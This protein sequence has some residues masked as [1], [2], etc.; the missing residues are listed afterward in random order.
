MT[1]NVAVPVIVGLAAGIAFLAIFSMVA[2]AQYRSHLSASDLT[3][4][5]TYGI[6]ARVAYAHTNTA[7]SCPIS[8]CDTSGFVL[9]MVSKHDVMILGYEVCNIGSTCLYDG[10]MQTPLLGTSKGINDDSL[11]DTDGLPIY[12]GKKSGGNVGDT[13]S[14]KVRAMPAIEK[15]ENNIATWYGDPS[16]PPRWIDLGQSRI[17][18]LDII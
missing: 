16:E 3:H 17:L 10:E 6:D 15:Q 7:V 11:T 5:N 4:D 18:E 2:I 13:V 12:L 14:I 1:D 8:P 9:M